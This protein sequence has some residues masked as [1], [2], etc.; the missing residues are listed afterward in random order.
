M[1]SL[2]ILPLLYM[3]IF[4]PLALRGLQ[5]LFITWYL[6]PKLGL[7]F[8]S[9][10]SRHSWRCTCTT[11]STIFFFLRLSLLLLPICSP[12]SLFVAS[13]IRPPPCQL[14]H[15]S[16]PVGSSLFVGRC[17]A[18]SSIACAAGALPQLLPLA[19]RRRHRFFNRAPRRFFR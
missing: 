5:V 8:L 9:S 2:Y 4:G 15:R 11:Q 10:P 12:G 3:Y 19:N 13:S 1:N 14:D 17:L 18:P 16:V 7:C 6:E